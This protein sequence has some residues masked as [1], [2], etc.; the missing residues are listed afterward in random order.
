MGP[1]WLKLGCPYSQNWFQY[2][3]WDAPREDP[4]TIQP[5]SKPY[6]TII[7]AI[8]W[9]V[10]FGQNCIRHSLSPEW[11]ISERGKGMNTRLPRHFAGEGREK[12]NAQP[13]RYPAWFQISTTLPMPAA[14]TDQFGLAKVFPLICGNVFRHCS[15]LYIIDLSSLIP[16]PL[17]FEVPQL[18]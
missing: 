14:C 6:Q 9:G 5:I 7:S 18:P 16:S 8:P 15:D 17:L 1:F 11:L 13:L 10:I 2:V 4:T 3:R 12:M